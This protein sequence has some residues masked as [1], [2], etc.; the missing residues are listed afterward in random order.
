MK[1]RSVLILAACCLPGLAQPTPSA[2]LLANPGFE[3]VQDGFPV[4]WGTFDEKARGLVTLDRREAFAGDYALRLTGDPAEVWQPLFSEGLKV[5]PAGAYTLGGYS[6]S[7]IN[8]G[9][10]IL[11]ALREISADGQSIRFSQVA[12]PLQ[13]DWA[14][15]SQKLVLTDKTTA[16]QVFI[17]LQKCAG[18]VWFD[19]LVLVA[20]DLPELAAWQARQRRPPAG[21]LTPET[22]LYNNLLTNNS[23]HKNVENAPQGWAWEA[24]GDAQGGVDE[25]RRFAGKATFRQEHARADLPGSALQTA[26]PVALTANAA[27]RLSGWVLTAAG[28]R[29][30]WTSVAPAR[31]QRAEGVCL[32]LLFLDEQGTLISQVWSPAIQTNG[33][34]QPL[35]VVGQAP[36]NAAAARVRLF[37]G[38]LQGTSWFAVPR[39][40]RLENSDDLQP[41][42]ALPADEFEPGDLPPTW[43]RLQAQ[44]QVQAALRAA[45]GAEPLVVS[46]RC[47]G[48][49]VGALVL[50]AVDAS[51][52]GTFKVTGE[53][54]LTGGAGQV[55]L[56]LASLSVDGAVLA[57]AEVPLT[58]AAAWTAFSTDYTPDPM[59][60]TFTAALTLDGT[61]LAVEAR[62]LRVQ[63]TARLTLAEYAAQAFT[64]AP[65]AAGAARAAG[66]PQVGFAV[67]R[68]LPT[69]TVN[70][71]AQSLSQYWHSAP[72][73]AT[74]IEA[75]RQAGLIQTLSL[76]EIDWGREPA[77]VDWDALDAQVRE[78]LRGAP[79]AWIMLCPDT[80]AESGPV[81]WVKHHPDQAYVNDLV[82]SDVKSYSGEQRLFPS[83]ASR[84][85]RD[86]VN[87]LLTALVAHVK[88]ADYGGRVIGYQ[89]SGYE[90]F[91]WEW[92]RARTDVSE[93]MRAAFAVWL[94]EAYGTAAALQ[95]AWNT[96]GLTFAQVQ[97]P[98]SAERRRTVDGVFRDP[99][100]Q[101][102]VLDFARFYHEQMA[103]VL[104]SQAQTIKQAAGQRTLVSCYYA[105]DVHM[106]DGLSRETSGHLALGKL[107]DSGLFEVIGAP[108]DGYLYERG[109]GGTGGFMTV[110]GSYA[111]HGARYLDQPDF[112]THWSPQD[113][114]RTAT[115]SADVQ[116]FRREFALALT[117]DVPLQYLDFSRQWTVGDRRLVAELQRF[118]EI[119]RFALTL[120]RTPRA[121]GM[122]VLFS[123][124]SADVIGTESTL[125]DGGLTY[126]QRPL[127]YRSGMPHRYYLLRDL[128]DP[129]LPE[130]TVWVFP[131]AFRL[132]AEERALV[133]RK[134]MRNGNVVVFIYA[135]GIVDAQRVA[136]DNMAELLGF[137]LVPLAG[138]SEA[139]VRIGSGA[140]VPWL[141]DS[142]GL[143]YGQGQW[144]PL[145]T[146][147][148]RSVQV[149]GNYVGSASPGLVCRDFGDYKV[150]YSGAPLLPPDLW[151]DLGRRAGSHVYCESSDALY[152][153]GDFIGLHARTPGRKRLALPQ[154]AAVYDLLQRRLLA[155]ETALIEVDMRGFDTAL[156]Y[157]GD[158]ARA[159]AFF[160]KPEAGR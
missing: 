4:G 104:I 111:L 129:R 146:T 94:Q 72:P 68:G 149:L 95:V 160:G 159:E 136:V 29:S 19:D 135:P 33:A 91:Q 45:A 40:Q 23:F 73:Q 105:Y 15:H 75:C 133:R 112:R 109:L 128:A 86:D 5:E 51:F 77:G 158:P 121:A 103:A 127:L 107:L 17:V 41:L 124:E 85:W 79:E 106:F 59:A 82:Q 102:P 12:L 44:G 11:F 26:A 90:W 99:L 115:V 1:L 20:G 137:T 46:G 139:R 71:Q 140:E 114:E 96:P 74:Q 37:H 101:R 151:R 84:L 13:A 32:Q 39:L 78:V 97:I 38:D 61:D 48:T 153:D 122:A 6:R 126:H 98:S 24:G 125:F 62:R 87:R 25:A 18:T 155:R 28:A 58:P 2:N 60:A 81:S 131:N 145:Y 31:G 34:W 70:G 10:Q 53:C 63:Q 144:S 142:A 134:C 130:Y 52:P 120:D 9:T 123:E 88:A 93:P 83:F 132:N 119:E 76:S 152:A 30:G 141:Q 80:T 138:Q 65:P 108:T 156:F 35:A 8:G 16:V 147:A 42:W 148:D 100:G 64:V 21:T 14:F 66:L 7:E 55:R 56:R 22:A 47:Q 157:T 143:T 154:P 118:A 57:Q 50:P 92:M 43:E 54:R 49:A 67:S 117:N 27:Y 110:P 3:Q 69:L 89:L 150:V 36:G 116:L 113:I